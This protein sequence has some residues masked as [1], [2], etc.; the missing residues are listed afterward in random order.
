MRRSHQSEQCDHVWEVVQGTDHSVNVQNSLDSFCGHS[1]RPR[2]V[3]Y[4][5]LGL[6]GECMLR[7]WYQTQCNPIWAEH[8]VLGKFFVNR[9]QLV[10]EQQELVDNGVK[11]DQWSLARSYTP[12]N[13]LRRKLIPSINDSL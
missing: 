12:Y 3:S 10:P 6:V 11:L 7:D 2:H 9:L 5:K 8:R 13:D 4:H 1:Y